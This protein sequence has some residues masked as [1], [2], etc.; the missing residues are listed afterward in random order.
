MA[1]LFPGVI[2]PLSSGLDFV[3]F[4]SEAR[5]GGGGCSRNYCAPKGCNHTN[6]KQPPPQEINYH[7]VDST[8][9]EA[10]VVMQRLSYRTET[11]LS[12]KIARNRI[13]LS[14]KDSPR[15]PLRRPPNEKRPQ[16]ES[17]GFFCLQL[18]WKIGSRSEGRQSASRMPHSPST[19]RG[20]FLHDLRRK[21]GEYSVGKIN[22]CGLS[23]FLFIERKISPL[24]RDGS[25]SLDYNLSQLFSTFQMLYRGV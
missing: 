15:K 21:N 18:I 20:E 22:D 7:V 12:N 10:N 23:P 24:R 6:T 8:R 11:V 19:Q 9:N 25:H 1:T 14:F 2:S 13:V 3:R 5:V 4:L 16:C 17:T